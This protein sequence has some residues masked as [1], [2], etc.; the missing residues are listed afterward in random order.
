MTALT[1]DELD[2]AIVELADD[3]HLHEKRCVRYPDKE[4]AGTHRHVAR[5]RRVL[6]VL[7]D[8]RDDS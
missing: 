5:L 4:L 8:M 7:R 1:R 3:L 6:E 2:A